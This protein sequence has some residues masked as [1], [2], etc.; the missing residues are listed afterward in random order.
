MKAF[1][2]IQSGVIFLAL[3]LIL[4]FSGCKNR[5]EKGQNADNAIFDTVNKEVIL[6]PESKSLLY[7]FPT[8][9]EVTKLLIAAQAGYISDITNPP[10][11]VVKYVTEQ[12]K[13]LNLGIYS[14]DLS[15]A[16]TYNQ[17]DDINKFLA[18][19]GKLADE[20]GIKGV[21]DKTLIE[22]VQKFNNNKDSLITMIT[23][24]FDQTNDF[25]SKNDRT[26]ITVLIT[27][28]GFAEG[29]YLASL[30]GEMA[31]DN[32]K[33]MAVIASQKENY[34]TLAMILDAYKDDASMKPVYDGILKLKPI[35]DNYDIGSGKKVTQQNAKEISLLTQS[36]RSEF[37]K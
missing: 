27:S 7:K 26:Q 19:T 36:V 9:F 6:T 11:N 17:N 18:S 16:T 8:P 24:V 30:L 10:D 15:Y 28:G 21:Y 1:T 23:K 33:I 29:I 2:K 34:N 31:K 3:F 35:W 13:A 14:A 25:L 4:V 5:G 20:L 12:S 22:K 37:I 32:T